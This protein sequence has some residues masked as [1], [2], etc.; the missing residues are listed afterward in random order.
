MGIKEALSNVTSSRHQER[1]RAYT[2][3]LTNNDQQQLQRSL[4]ST[5]LETKKT[6]ILKVNYQDLSKP[7]LLHF[8]INKPTV[9]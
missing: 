8:L 6:I 1:P 2:C 7:V 3:M 9:V 5:L 4:K